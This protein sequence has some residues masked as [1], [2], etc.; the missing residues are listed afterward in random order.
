[1]A[2]FYSPPCPWEGEA[3]LIPIL[4]KREWAGQGP[5]QRRLSDLPVSVCVSVSVFLSFFFSFSLSL[6]LHSSHTT[7]SLFPVPY[8]VC[9]HL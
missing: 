6:L 7:S 1:M 4:Q 8:R 2:S 3:S 9:S 5:H